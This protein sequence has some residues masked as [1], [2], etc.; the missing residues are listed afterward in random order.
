[1]RIRR[2]KEEGR[3]FESQGVKYKVFGYWTNDSRKQ[4]REKPTYDNLFAV[5]AKPLHD[6]SDELS[7]IPKNYI[8]LDVYEKLEA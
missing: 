4:Q 1:M 3:I 7:A 6:S 8:P 2:E 5:V